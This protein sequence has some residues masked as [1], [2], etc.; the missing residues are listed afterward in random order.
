MRYHE[1]RTHELLT[2]ATYLAL[3]GLVDRRLTFATL[4]SAISDRDIVP[5]ERGI[6]SDRPPG[7]NK[8]EYEIG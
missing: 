4:I 1:L 8:A 3:R 5:W 7:P 2:V 6:D